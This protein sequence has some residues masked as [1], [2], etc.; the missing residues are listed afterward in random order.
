MRLT[1]HEVAS[2]ATA[3]EAINEACKRNGV[4]LGY[5][6]SISLANNDTVTLNLLWDEDGRAYV[7]D[8]RGDL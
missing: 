1:A 2:I 3:L 4:R 7:I 5:T 6:P 8:H